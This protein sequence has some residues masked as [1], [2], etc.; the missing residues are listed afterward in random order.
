MRGPAGAEPCL[1][2]G[3]AGR[4]MSCCR[5]LSGVAQA[6]ENAGL[7]FEIHHFPG[8]QICCCGQMGGSEDCVLLVL[9][10]TEE[11]VEPSSWI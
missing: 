7:W 5:G 3:G 1:G 6:S 8:W 11:D 4:G 9:Q 2:G 10:G